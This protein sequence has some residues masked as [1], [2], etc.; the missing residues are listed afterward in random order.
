VTWRS[1]T[2]KTLTIAPN[3]YVTYVFD[4]KY[5]I[6]GVPVLLLYVVA[7]AP[8]VKIAV[9]NGSGAPDT[10]YYTDINPD[11]TISNQL[12]WYTLHSSANLTLAGSTKIYVRIFPGLDT[13]CTIS[14]IFVY[15]DLE[16]V[17]AERFTITPGGTNYI[18][19]ETAGD[20]NSYISLYYRDRKW[21]I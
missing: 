5:P 18:Q 13:L 8:H 10:L 21:I 6:T 20:P 15:A 3:G 4:V 9:D 17:D 12:R 16:T 7:G 2:D 14:S 1:D 11:A 19:V